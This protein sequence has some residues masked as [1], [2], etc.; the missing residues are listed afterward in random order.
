MI[1]NH[2]KAEAL[3]NL[4][5]CPRNSPLD[6]ISFVEGFVYLLR[7]KHSVSHRA[8]KGGVLRHRSHICRRIGTE[9]FFVI[10]NDSSTSRAARL[11]SWSCDARGES[12]R[13]L[14]MQVISLRADREAAA[15]SSAQVLS[16]SFRSPV[17]GSEGVYMKVLVTGGAGFIGSHTC[18]ALAEWGH[19]PIVYDSLYT[20][21]RDAVLWGRSLLAISSILPVWTQRFQF[22]ARNW[23]C[24]SPRWRTSASSS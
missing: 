9:T 19:Q 5:G 13:R 2:M 17:H 18:K 8:R 3:P 20:G 11:I 16:I 21:H 7:V 22:I 14:D 12:G 1:A 15:S 23:S 24:T 6:C 10:R 4:E